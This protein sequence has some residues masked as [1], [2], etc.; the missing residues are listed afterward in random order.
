MVLLT[1]VPPHNSALPLTTAMGALSHPTAYIFH[2][3]N[4]DPALSLV[5]VFVQAVVPPLNVTAIV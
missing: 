2:Q 4:V 5:P 1:N 3:A